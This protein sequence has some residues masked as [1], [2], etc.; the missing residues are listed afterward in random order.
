MKN[1]ALQVAFHWTALT[2]TF[3][4][5][6]F[7]LFHEFSSSSAP[8][9]PSNY[10]APRFGEVPKVRT[11]EELIPAALKIV[12]GEPV[13]T[14]AMPGGSLMIPRYGIKGGE[15]VLYL[16]E[17]SQDPLVVEAFVEAFRRANAKVDVLLTEGAQ[18]LEEY[19]PAHRF[20][21]DLAFY[22]KG[23]RMGAGRRPQQEYAEGNKYDRLIGMSSTDEEAGY[24]FVG[25]YQLWH[26]RELLAGPGAT[27]PAELQ[28]AIDQKAWGLL[29][30]AEKVHL[31]EP[32]GTD[33]GFTWFKDWWL[34]VAGT[35]PNIET[36][37]RYGKGN[38]ETPLFGGHLMGHPRFGMIPNA[39]ATGVISGTAGHEGPWPRLKVTYKNNRIVQIEGEGQVADAWRT[40]Y[41]DPNRWW[42][43]IQY[44]SYPTPG[45]PWLVEWSIGTNPKASRPY[46]V[47][48]S[49]AAREDWAYERARSG[50][51]HIGHGSRGNTGWGNK[52]GYPI[53]HWHF[54][55]CFPT[56]EITDREGKKHVLV[57]K[58]HLTLLDDP[59]IRKIAAK[60][61]NPDELLK[62]YWI[63]AIPGIN[64]AGNYLEDYAK[65]PARWLRQF[66]QWDGAELWWEKEVRRAQPLFGAKAR[67][68]RQP[69]AM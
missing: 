8:E 57:D 66:K 9:Q 4:V 5:A 33:I 32:E 6:A 47:M 14:D 46:G 26:T 54:E 20:E 60:Y 2:G 30:Q 7:F 36:K 42:Q 39:D 69:E 64:Y 53:Y 38:T 29:R 50:V 67:E 28:F 40:A 58:G 56:Y 52:R 25:R 10:P 62:E 12:Q 65:D 44:P 3:A 59:E 55:I 31:T 49:I 19:E 61:G 21:R 43:K 18:S 35:H 1:K 45:V 37:P 63:P 34:I 48:A 51:M 15:K 23:P 17:T 22:E 16:A 24:T 41:L 68:G 13:N 11:V 27:F